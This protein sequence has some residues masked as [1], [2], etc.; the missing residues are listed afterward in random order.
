MKKIYK[1]VTSDIYADEGQNTIEVKLFASKE[2]ALEYMNKK[3][4]SAEEDISKDELEKYTTEK[5]KEYYERYLTGYKAIDSLE[6]WLEE[7]ELYDEK[8]K[9]SK[10]KREYESEYLL[11]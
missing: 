10:E 5:S 2:L 9:Q 4:R 11:D 8:F 7:D 6:I 1:I 3:I